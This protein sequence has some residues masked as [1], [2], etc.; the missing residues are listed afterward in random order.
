MHVAKKART[1]KVAAKVK[2]QNLSLSDMHIDLNAWSKTASITHPDGGPLIMSLLGRGLILPKKGIK[3]NEKYNSTSMVCTLDDEQE[4]DS[5]LALE[6][7]VNKFIESQQ[8]ILSKNGYDP[9]TQFYNLVQKRNPDA[10]PGLKPIMEIRLDPDNISVKREDTKEKI[11]DLQICKGMLWTSMQVEVKSIFFGKYVSLSCRIRKVNVLPG[12]EWKIAFAGESDN[13]KDGDWRLVAKTYDVSK[14]DL[15][16]A[17]CGNLR[18]DK[19]RI[20]MLKNPSDQGPICIQLSQGGTIPLKFGFEQN[21]TG[22]HMMTF[23]VDSD[24]EDATMRRINQSMLSLVQS[25]K[26]DWMPGSISDV[27]G[28]AIPIITEKKKRPDSDDEFYPALM[29]ATY[30]QKPCEV[31]VDGN[32]VELDMDQ[33]KGMKWSR[34]VIELKC[35]YFQ[36]KKQFGVSKHVRKIDFKEQNDNYVILSSDDDQD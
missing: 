13:K 23:T 15:G 21:M 17:M 14:F 30:G 27:S 19:A 1:S 16:Q 20:V 29:K 6:G 9:E 3:H 11:T 25:N 31:F 36:G 35:F 24:E 5:L 32:E 8:D 12:Q 33:M 7:Q 22:K 18:V 26:D 28:L 4:Y 2:A 10:P 34:I